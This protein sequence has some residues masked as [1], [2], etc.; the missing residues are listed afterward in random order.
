MERDWKRIKFAKHSPQHLSQYGVLQGMEWAEPE[1][2]C[3]GSRLLKWNQRIIM[4]STDGCSSN[5]SCGY[6]CP[7]LSAWPLSAD[8]QS[9]Q[10]NSHFDWHTSSAAWP[11]SILQSQQPVYH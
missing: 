5:R 2:A 9:Q 1:L 3:G 11:L 4:Q 6:C 8:D 10:P 7:S